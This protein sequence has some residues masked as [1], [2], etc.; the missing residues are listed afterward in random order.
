[1]ALHGDDGAQAGSLGERGGTDGRAVLT[2]IFHIHFQP[3]GNCLGGRFVG[4]G[5]NGG[6]E[7]SVGEVLHRRG[8]AQRTREDRSGAGRIL[9]SHPGMEG[10]ALRLFAQ[11]VVGN[12]GEGAFLGRQH[13]VWHVLHE[14]E[15][16]GHPSAE[17]QGI[18]G[19]HAVAEGGAKGEFVELVFGEG[20]LGAVQEG[21]GEG[22]L[23]A[24]GIGR[25][26]CPP[27]L[28]T[29]ILRRAQAVHAGQVGSS[30][31]GQGV[32]AVCLVQV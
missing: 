4:L 25:C 7:F 31:Y 24:Q 30:G 5:K 1:M 19:Q 26:Q 8:T 28:V 23:S 20:A 18:H 21:V 11:M 6:V 29:Q 9:L 3:V 16:I 17:G 32:Q 13:V 2:Y 15:G 27:G 10:A 14:G 12:G 22:S